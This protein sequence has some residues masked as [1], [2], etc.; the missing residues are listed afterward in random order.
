MIWLGIALILIG[1]IFGFVRLGSQFFDILR[2]DFSGVAGNVI[3]LILAFL[4]S[5]IGLVLLII[6]IIIN[7]F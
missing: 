2:M 4:L 6:G 5:G 1:I 7:L 3:G